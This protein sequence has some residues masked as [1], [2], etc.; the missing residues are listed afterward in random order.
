MSLLVPGAKEKG[1]C[2]ENHLPCFGTISQRQGNRA[3]QCMFVTNGLRYLL[4]QRGYKLVLT[5]EE[6]N[7]LVSQ[8][9]G[10]SKQS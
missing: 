8:V 6:V 7:Q 4:T 1:I 5:L 9:K 10:N 2:S 3:S